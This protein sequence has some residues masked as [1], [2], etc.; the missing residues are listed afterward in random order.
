MQKIFYA[1][2]CRKSQIGTD[3]GIQ[4]SS[5]TFLDG[6]FLSFIWQFR[7]GDNEHEY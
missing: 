2:P 5:S 3:E 7:D 6:N 4:W 1:Q